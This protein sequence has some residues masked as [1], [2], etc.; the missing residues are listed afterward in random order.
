[1]GQMVELRMRVPEEDLELLRAMGQGSGEDM[2]EIARNMLGAV[3][4][5]KRREYEV[6]A[7]ILAAPTREHRGNRAGAVAA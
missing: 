1:M 2:Q 4:H 7:R 3:L 6:V 5:R